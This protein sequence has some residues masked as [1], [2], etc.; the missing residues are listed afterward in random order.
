MTLARQ[1]F[2][3]SVSRLTPSPGKRFSRLGK[4]RYAVSHTERRT[5]LY[6]PCS[7]VPS[8]G[9]EA[10][11][12]QVSHYSSAPPPTTSHHPRRPVLASR[13]SRCPLSFACPPSVRQPGGLG[14]SL[15][16]S[17]APS[18]RRSLA[19]ISRV[20]RACSSPAVPTDAASGSFQ[21]LSP[22]D[23]RLSL[24]FCNP[25]PEYPISL[26][27]GY[28]VQAALCVDRLPLVY[29]EPPYE[30]H[31]RQFKAKWEART[32]NGLEL[33]DEITFMKFPFHFF[34]TEQIQKQKEELISKTGDAE[35][36]ELELL[37]S[38]EG[39]SGTRALKQDKR[40]EAEPDDASTVGTQ[41][42]GHQ[43]GLRSLEREPRKMLY[44]IV[45]YGNS[46][47]FPL[48]DRI[49][50]QSMRRTLHRL[51]K[52]QLGA[53]YSPFH[54][55]YCPFYYD[56]RTYK[57]PKSP[58]LGRKIFYYRA[59]HVPGGA[60]VNIPESSPVNDYAWV[61]REELPAY[62]SERKARA[63]LPGLMLE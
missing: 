49:H 53:E 2:S 16:T 24:F 4:P 18:C 23:R 48:A 8:A 27:G 43:G 63:V 56:K 50:G 13:T 44:L 54:L 33:A 39:F 51:C 7:P 30:S 5:C 59:H 19:T 40:R 42:L 31:W 11:I 58:V 22:A 46:W 52:E 3:S 41:K 6:V 17:S 15:C 55:G 36:S 57:E 25:P 10:S 26:H 60:H 34:E 37:L 32:K 47:Q 29:E 61:T 20:D 14:A 12:F 45:K 62:L 21:R 28:K 1:V 9:Q 35:V 38:Q